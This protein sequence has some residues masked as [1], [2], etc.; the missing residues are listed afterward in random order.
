MALYRTKVEYTGTG[1][2]LPCIRH[3]KRSKCSPWWSSRVHFGQLKSKT[4]PCS[5][6]TFSKEMA[7]IVFSTKHT[8]TIADGCLRTSGMYLILHADQLSY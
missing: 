2:D 3:P 7:I 1:T 6:Y 8:A 5:N 4:F